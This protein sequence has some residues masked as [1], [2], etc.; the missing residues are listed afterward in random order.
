M[1]Q[2]MLVVPKDR[3][4]PKFLRRKFQE[5][6]KGGKSRRKRGIRHQGNTKRFGNKNKEKQK[7]E[8]FYEKARGDSFQKFAGKIGPANVPGQPG[9]TTSCPAGATKAD[10][11]NVPGQPG[12]T[13]YCSAGATDPTDPTDA[14]EA[15]FF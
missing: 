12:V 3:M 9:V 4:P 13:T 5:L 15:L 6:K 11:T 10:F 7:K 8:N 1:Q 14:A 2:K